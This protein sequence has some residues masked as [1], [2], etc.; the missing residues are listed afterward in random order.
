MGWLI[1]YYF[2]YDRKD[3]AVKIAKDG[4][5]VFSYTGL[6]TMS[7]LLERMGQLDDAEQYLRKTADRYPSA[8]GELRDFYIRNHEKSPNYAKAADQL[9]QKTFPHGIEK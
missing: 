7:K 6:V 9:Q 3:D 5:E 2:D 1:N 8:A 4:A